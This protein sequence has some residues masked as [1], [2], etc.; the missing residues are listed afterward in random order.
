MI[1]EQKKKAFLQK[2]ANMLR[3]FEVTKEEV[4]RYLVLEAESQAIR[5]SLDVIGN[6]DPKNKFPEDKLTDFG[7]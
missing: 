7:K 1:E 6:P 2:K 3:N 4:N 5:N